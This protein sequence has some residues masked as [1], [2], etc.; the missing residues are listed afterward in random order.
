MNAYRYVLSAAFLSAALAIGFT[1][2]AG[3][4]AAPDASLRVGDSAPNVRV[5]DHR[6]ELWS[7]NDQTGDQPVVLYF[8]PAAMTRGCTK[9]ACSYR[10]NQ[11]TLNDQGVRVIGI[12]GD[13]VRNLQ[14]FRSAHNLNFTLLSDP[15]GSVAR[16]FGVPVGEGGSIQRT[17]DGEEHTLKRG[18]TFERWTFVIDQEGT[19][20]YVNRDVTPSEDPENIRSVVRKLMDK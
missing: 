4:T 12:S 17:I 11:S 10:D 6:G 20:A 13:P 9:Q 16:K 19:I 14:L 15:D 3:T 7:L 18:G 2:D 8:Y 5:N 1:F